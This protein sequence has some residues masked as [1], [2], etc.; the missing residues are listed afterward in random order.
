MST[1]GFADFDG[2]IFGVISAMEGRKGHLH[3]FHSIKSLLESKQN[4]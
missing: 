3:L 2:T 1:L 4:T